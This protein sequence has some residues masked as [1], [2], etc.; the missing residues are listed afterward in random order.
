MAKLEW[1]NKLMMARHCRSCCTRA[2]SNMSPTPSPEFGPVGDSRRGRGSST[3]GKTAYRGN[4]RLTAATFRSI[5]RPHHGTAALQSYVAGRGS[6]NLMANHIVVAYR[7][8]LGLRFRHLDRFQTLARLIEEGDSVL[9]R[10]DSSRWGNGKRRSR[11]HRRSRNVVRCIA[12]DQRPCRPQCA[13]KATPIR[14]PQAM[15]SVR[16]FGQKASIGTSQSGAPSSG[17]IH[18]LYLPLTRLW[19]SVNPWDPQTSEIP[20][21]ASICASTTPLLACRILRPHIL[22]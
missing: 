18:R 2:R 1:V 19:H 21:R 10:V 15:H 22:Q 7:N 16:H 17:R 14:L 5:L 3:A 9:F 6:A 12:R 11:T 20:H 13:C 8:D 4:G